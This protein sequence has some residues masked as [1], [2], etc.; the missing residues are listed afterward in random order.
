MKPMTAAT[1]ANVAKVYEL[2]RTSKGTVRSAHIGEEAECGVTISQ[3]AK[4]GLR[5]L[6]EIPLSSPALHM[7]GSGSATQAAKEEN[8][9]TTRLQFIGEEYDSV[10]VGA[11]G[12]EL[13]ITNPFDASDKRT[14]HLTVKCQ[15]NRADATQGELRVIT[16][17]L[18]GKGA[19]A[20][21]TRTVQAK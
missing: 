19:V 18:A 10:V 11:D 5:L 20:K 12:K 13:T 1:P 4:G 2:P 7:T 9:G 14:V 3:D 6:L 8:I 21:K 17:A 15:S 16:E